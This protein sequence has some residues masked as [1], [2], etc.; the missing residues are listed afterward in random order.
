MSFDS[1]TGC[2]RGKSNSLRVSPAMAAGL[3]DKLWSLDD[4]VALIQAREPPPKK[5]GP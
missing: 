2:S 4:V 5:R 1:N 3:T